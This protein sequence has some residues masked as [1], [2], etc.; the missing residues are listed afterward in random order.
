MSGK[1]TGHLFSEIVRPPCIYSIHINFLCHLVKM[2]HK[3]HIGQQFDICSA[4]ENGIVRYQSAESIKFFTRSSQ[5]LETA[6]K[7][8]Q[9]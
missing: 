1:K 7:V 2:A 9:C 4:F 5:S 6:Q 8:F 3:V